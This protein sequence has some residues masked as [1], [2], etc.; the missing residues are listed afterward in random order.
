M[1]TTP[2]DDST[3]FHYRGTTARHCSHTPYYC[4]L[5]HFYEPYKH[6]RHYLGMTG[7]LDF[8]LAR[9]QAG[10]GAR[11]ME[12]ITQAGITFEVA[13]LWQCEDYASARALER[14]LKNVHGH[15]PA[16]C[17]ICSHKPLDPLVSLRQGHWPLALHS[18]IGRR[19]PSAAWQNQP[20]ERR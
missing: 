10:T 3:I 5:L 12:V 6:A 9:H 15:G 19:R 7:A 1:F 13:R 20:F 17:A 18:R 2:A 8:R 14:K 16:L 11:L 4:Y